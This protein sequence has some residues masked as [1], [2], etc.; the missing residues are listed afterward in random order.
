MLLW[1]THFFILRGIENAGKLNFVATAAKVTGFLLFIIVAIFAFQKSN[2]LPFI[3][4]RLDDQG[5]TVSLFG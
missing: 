4:P 1:G 5:N 3:E 2:I